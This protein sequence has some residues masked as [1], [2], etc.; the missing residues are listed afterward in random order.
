MFKIPQ[1][2]M[3]LNAHDVPGARYK[4]WNTWTVPSSD[5][6]KH[7]LDWTGC[8]AHSA[9]GGYLPSVVLNCHGFYGAQS[10]TGT[11]V[12]GFGL[13]MGTGIRRADTALFAAL[14]PCVSCIWITACGTARIS[15]VS[16]GD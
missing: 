7:I 1:P 13:K 5:N 2:A 3:A 6:A 9:P 10:G 11:T 14:A 15:G 4:M 8:V 12:G 16:W